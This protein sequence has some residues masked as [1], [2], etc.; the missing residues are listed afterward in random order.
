MNINFDQVKRGYE[1]EIGV[2][3]IDYSENVKECLQG[4]TEGKSDTVLYKL[5]IYI[6]KRNRSK[7]KVI[8]Y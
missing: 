5:K 1:F 4:E 6:K 3:R 2:I 8:F 7:I